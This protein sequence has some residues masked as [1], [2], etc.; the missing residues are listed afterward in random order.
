MCISCAYRYENGCIRHRDEY[1][2]N[3]VPIN[4]L[5]PSKPA[6]CSSEYHQ[7]RYVDLLSVI[8]S[9]PQLASN[10]SYTTHVSGGKYSTSLS[11][12]YAFNYLSLRSKF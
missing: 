8:V 10:S 11:L 3:D 12:I 4:R 7:G 2:P 6:L 9:H 1:V 5:M